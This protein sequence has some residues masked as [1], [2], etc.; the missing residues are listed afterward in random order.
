MGGSATRSSRRLTSSP[1]SATSPRSRLR[2]GSRA[3]RSCPL[4]GASVTKSTRPSSP[5]S[6]ITPPTSR[7][8]PYARRAGNISAASGRA[9]DRC[10]PTATTARARTCGATA[11]GRRAL[12]FRSNST[13]SSLTRKGPPI[14]HPIRPSVAP[15]RSY[16]D[17]SRAGWRRPTTRYDTDP[18]PRQPIRGR[19]ILTIGHRVRRHRACGWAEAGAATWRKG[20]SWLSVRR[21]NQPTSC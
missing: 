4:Y 1:P 20:K 6:P 19:T 5:K 11:A 14:W 2:P 10:A 9:T 17:I 7:N 13:I 18:S 16:G 8:A 12:S 21:R 3:G 15:W